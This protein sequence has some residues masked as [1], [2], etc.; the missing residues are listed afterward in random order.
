MI[1]HMARAKARFDETTQALKSHI[2]EELDDNHPEGPK[3]S[4]EL[5]EHD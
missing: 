3:S 2:A 1:G 5:G 4:P